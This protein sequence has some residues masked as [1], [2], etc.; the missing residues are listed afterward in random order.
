V[1]AYAAEVRKLADQL[2]QAGSDA[3]LQQQLER[4]S[5]P[6][7]RAQGAAAGFRNELR[8]HRAEVEGP[9]AKLG[10]LTEGAKE[11][12]GVFGVSFGI[13]QIAEGIGRLAEMGERFE[14]SAAAIGAKAGDY[15]KLAGAFQLVG[16]NAKTAAR[17][18]QLVE[19]NITEALATR[20]RQRATPLPT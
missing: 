1:R 8:S 19:R 13:E 16:G 9:G 7:A 2:R 6:L 12:A 5:E 10:E 3:S 11:L 18:I 14:N 4:A 20:T 17:T 15:A